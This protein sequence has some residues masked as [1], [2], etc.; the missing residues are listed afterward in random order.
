MLQHAAIP[1]RPSARLQAAI[2]GS[3]FVGDSVKML[4]M[5][6]F[7]ISAEWSVCTAMHETYRIARRLLQ[8][9][10]PVGR[11]RTFDAAADGYGRGEG[12]VSIVLKPAAHD[13]ATEGGNSSGFAVMRGSA[14]N[15][16][17]RSSSLTAP[18][19]PSQSAL[20]SVALAAAGAQYDCSREAVQ[21]Q[22]Q[23][24][25]KSPPRR[26]QPAAQGSNCTLASRAPAEG[27]LSRKCASSMRGTLR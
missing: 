25:Q 21:L 26:A 14:V 15:Q 18:N 19:G 23:A 8:A 1:P 24:P 16:D 7:Q 4:Q 6:A 3:L 11:C 27:H 5:L 20:I 12:C 17:G 10:S 13:G 2:V 9:L 22:V